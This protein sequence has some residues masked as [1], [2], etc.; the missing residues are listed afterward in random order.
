MTARIVGRPD[1]YLNERAYQER[2]KEQLQRLYPG[3]QVETQWYP[4]KGDDRNMYWPVVDIAVGPFAMHERL[5]HRYTKLMLDRRAIIE[6][7]IEVHNSNVEELGERMD[8]GT[9]L[10]F[11]ENARCLF[12]IEIEESGSRKHCLGNLVNAS[13][14]GRIGLL[15]ARNE[16]ILNIFVRERAYLKF[17]GDVDK[18]T[19]KTANALVVTEEQFDRW[20]GEH[21]GR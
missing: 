9:L 12:C 13:A 19:F 11:N 5:G 20:L 6:R 4:F 17:I 2:A 21:A 15:V 3:E 16:K 14:L 10:E 7:L 8:F 1:G 18:N